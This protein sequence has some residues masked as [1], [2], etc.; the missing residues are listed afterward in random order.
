[1]APVDY[2]CTC[3]A[4]LRYKQDLTK[5]RGGIYPNWHCKDCGTPVPNKIAEQLKHQHP[6]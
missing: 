5:E 6:S 1:M 2:Q 3:G 4:T